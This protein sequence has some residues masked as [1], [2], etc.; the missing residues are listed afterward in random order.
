MQ[1]NDKKVG[2]PYAPYFKLIIKK[3]NIKL[4]NQRHLYTPL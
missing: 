2:V 4:E 3:G 1:D